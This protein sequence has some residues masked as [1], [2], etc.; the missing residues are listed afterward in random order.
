M[1][2]TWILVAFIGWT[3]PFRIDG[4]HSEA[5]CHRIGA[6]VERYC[7]E[8][9]QKSCNASHYCIPGPQRTCPG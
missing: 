5:E 7:T 2:E 3:P 4:L 9:D 8:R 6:I 1:C